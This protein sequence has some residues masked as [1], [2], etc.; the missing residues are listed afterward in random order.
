MARS[1]ALLAFSSA[2][3]AAQTTTVSLLLPFADPQKIVAS[4]VAADSTATTYVY[5]CPPGTQADD[6][7]FET[8]QTIT[9]GPSTWIYTNTYS[10]DDGGVYTQGGNCKL[11]SSADRAS[12]SVWVSGSASDSVMASASQG[13]EAFLTWELP[14]TVTAGVEKLQAAPGATATGTDGSTAAP[15]N[16]GASESSQT[17]ASTGAASTTLARQT[18]AASHGSS[19]RTASTTAGPTS[20]NAAGIVNAQNGLLAGVAALVGGVMML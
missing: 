12:C 11:T 9:Q 13:T 14:V 2:V 1:L 17:T 15:T 4:V 5:G 10:G 16:T 20:T 18:T 3:M 19:T 6:C 7:G 8:S